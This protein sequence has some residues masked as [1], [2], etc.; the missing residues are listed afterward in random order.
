MAETD[1]QTQRPRDGFARATYVRRLTA[2]PTV[3]GTSA[4]NVTNLRLAVNET[5]DPS[6]FDVV[7]WE[8]TGEIAA[9]HLR[10]GARVLVDGRLQQ[11]RWEDREGGR[12]ER[13]ELVA[14]TLRFLGG[15]RREETVEAES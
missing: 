10:T 13:V 5:D 6:Y 15:G 8:K 11:R 3:R 4:G 7:L 14:D 1:G 2:D 9:T 12:H